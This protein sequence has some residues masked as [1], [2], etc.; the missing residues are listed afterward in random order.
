[1]KSSRLLAS[2]EK[3]GV[4]KEV[5]KLTAEREQ[6]LAE[7]KKERVQAEADRVSVRTEMDSLRMRLD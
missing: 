6:I 5:R 7:A 3:E 2:G 1:M 4:V